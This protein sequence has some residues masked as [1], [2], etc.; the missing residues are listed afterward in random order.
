[1]HVELFIL[2]ISFFCVIMFF[3][4]SLLYHL[5]S[6]LSL[7]LQRIIANTIRQVRHCR[8]QPFSK[9]AYHFYHTHMLASHTS[10]Q[11]LFFPSVSPLTASDPDICQP[12]K[13]QAE[14]RGYVRKLCVID[15]QRALTQLSYR[16]EP[17]RT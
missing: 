4:A 12:N 8:S 13:N 5:K 14:V 9:S 1:M 6:L 7:S 16:M 2:G 10:L 3:A 17:R 11:S 15:N